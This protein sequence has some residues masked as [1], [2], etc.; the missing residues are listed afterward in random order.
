MTPRCFLATAACL[1]L[2]AA[3]ALAGWSPDGVTIT[4]TTASIP[5]LTACSDGGFGTFV[6][7]QE[8]A[9]PG[10]GILKIQ[11]VLP[12][13]DLDGAWPAEGAIA[14][15]AEAARSP[16][17][18]LPDDLGGVYVWWLEGSSFYLTR[19]AA[20]GSVAAGWPAR[21]RLLGVAGETTSIP[22]V[23]GD[24]MNGVYAA[25]AAS[26]PISVDPVTPLAVHLGPSNTGAGGWPN[27]P[28]GLA[29]STAVATYEFWPRLALAPDGGIFAAWATCSGDTD[30]APSHWHLGRRTSA[31]VP[32]PGWTAEG[33]DWGPVGCD[34]I[35]NPNVGLVDVSPD[36]RGGAFLLIANPT[37][38]EYGYTEV[39][40]LIYR[41]L[42]DGTSAPDWPADGRLFSS[43]EAVEVNSAEGSYRVFGDGRDGVLAGGPVTYTDSP[44]YYGLNRFSGDGTSAGSTQGAMAG[45]ELALKGDGGLFFAEFS[46]TGPRGLY[47]P[48]AY[49]HVA[50]TFGPDAWS[51]WWEVH[52][53]VFLAW[54]GDIGL[55]STGDG[56]AVFYWSQVRDRIGLFARR[57]GPTGQTTAV[58]STCGPLA[59][60]S[61]RF[62]S[63]RGVVASIMIPRTSSGRLE[64]FDVL[65]RRVARADLERAAPG[66][67]EIDI[68]VTA[69]LHAGLY[70]ASLTTGS[71]HGGGRVVVAR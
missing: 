31:G 22:S 18:A 43:S 61:L 46:P 26:N 9:T 50:Q 51:D 4:P 68:P 11:H 62:V 33:M 12:A 39:R 54:Y 37:G 42:G 14:C 63:G 35:Q 53:E 19:V 30:V 32:A 36:G 5:K 34:L 6:A 25:W 29:P 56:G 66:L 69:G 64:L 21:G 52:S 41:L 48:P 58:P 65:G 1:V 45:H 71:G 60:R 2:C 55:A 38:A 67:Q 16:L 20:D 17:G 44:P 59:L 49:Q 13:G 28:R 23:I 3:P 70:F 27:S 10:Q 8:E 24:G 15:A 7:W 47:E 57:F 40:P